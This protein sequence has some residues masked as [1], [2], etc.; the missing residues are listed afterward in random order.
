M[1]FAIG[2]DAAFALFKRF[3]S[4]FVIVPLLGIIAWLLIRLYGFLSWD[5]ALDTI[6]KQDVVIAEMEKASADNL[7]AQIAQRNAQIA[8]SIQDAKD[9]ERAET[10]IKV[11]YR[12]R[13]GAY[14]DRM[15]ADNACQRPAN[16]PG[17]GPASPQPDS[18]G[19]AAVILTRSDFDQLVEN[20]ARLEAAHRWAQA[21]IDDGT[22]EAIKAGVPEVGF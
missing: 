4:L 9:N 21:L 19:P 14:A 7:A 20:S 8:K 11:V 12:D 22:A 18:P 5:G 15:R 2:L 3:K 6:A 13:A 10:Q 16:S 1:P 17:E